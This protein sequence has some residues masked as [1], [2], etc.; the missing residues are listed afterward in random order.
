MVKI[1]EVEQ[2]LKINYPLEIKRIVNEEETFYEFSYPDLPGLSIYVKTI[3]EGIEVIGEVK[4]EWFQTA[5]DNGFE[6]PEPHKQ[7]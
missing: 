7:I 4:R 3:D 5:L 6:I 2:Y 1:N